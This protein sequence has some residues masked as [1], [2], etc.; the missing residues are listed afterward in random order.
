MSY[1]WDGIFKMSII[2]FLPIFLLLSCSN[3]FYQ[4][5]SF[6]YSDP[7]HFKYE[8]SN[9]KIPSTDKVSLHA[10]HFKNISKVKTKGVVLFFHGNAQNISSH[11]YSVAWLSNHGYEVVV[12]D[13]RGYGLSTGKPNQE[14]V[15]QDALA[16]MNYTYEHYKKNNLKEFIIYGQ[17]LGGAISLRALKDFK[18]RKDIYLFV[19]D[20]TFLNYKDI[21]FDRL[22]TFWLTLPFSPLAYILVSNEYSPEDFAEKLEVPTL[23]I[24]GNNDKIVPYKFG[25]EVFKTLP[26][27]NKEMWTIE[28]GK[29]TDIFYRQDVDYKKKFINYLK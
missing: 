14:G 17:S 28:G 20:S 27:G 13:Y 26:T 15:N 22:T 24:H 10:W 5:N 8:F 18:H 2:K 25:E 1:R 16:A 12:V 21:A 19:L 6:L 9:V 4:P 7:H 11:Y 23:V 29:H 3:L